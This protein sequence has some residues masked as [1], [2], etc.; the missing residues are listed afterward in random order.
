MGVAGSDGARGPIHLWVI[1]T[2][3][4]WP[5]LKLGYFPTWSIKLELSS[6]GRDLLKRSL[7]KHGVL[8]R[9]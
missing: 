8:A 6:E 5:T 1:G 9:E 2:I 3:G 4:P 7:L